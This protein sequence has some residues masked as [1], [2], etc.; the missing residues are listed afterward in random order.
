M[1]NEEFVPV[2][3]DLRLGDT[4]FDIVKGL[5]LVSQM[6]N[7][8]PINPSLTSVVAGDWVVLGNDGTLSAVGS[9]SVPNTY[10]VWVGN[11]SFDSI[12]TGKATVIMGG[13]YRVQTSKYDK[14]ASYSVGSNLTLKGSA[15]VPTLA[16]GSDAWVARVTKVPGAD[17]IIEFL[18][19]NR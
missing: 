11:D 4:R 17:G 2:T 7:D 9:G 1:A 3:D 5:E 19:L 10:P 15:S 8:L 18:V 13:G 14:S 6:L 12:A 16:G